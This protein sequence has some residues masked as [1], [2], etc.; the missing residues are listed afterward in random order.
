MKDILFLGNMK[1][2]NEEL[3]FNYRENY[4]SGHIN[5]WVYKKYILLGGL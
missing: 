4:A 5:S 3:P 2:P 1:Y